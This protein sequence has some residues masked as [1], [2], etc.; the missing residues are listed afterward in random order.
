MP[1]AQEV[2]VSDKDEQASKATFPGVKYSYDYSEGCWQRCTEKRSNETGGAAK[3]PPVT[4]QANDKKRKE[5]KLLALVPGKVIEHDGYQ[6][7]PE[8]ILT[9]DR[10]LI[11]AT[12]S[13]VVVKDAEEA[14]FTLQQMFSAPAG[15]SRLRSNVYN[16]FALLP[17]NELQCAGA[18]LETVVAAA[19]EHWLLRIDHNSLE[20]VAY[21][22]VKRTLLA[23]GLVDDRGCG[24]WRWDPKKAATTLKREAACERRKER[25]PTMCLATMRH[26]VYLMGAMVLTH[27]QLRKLKWA[28][29][30]DLVSTGR[31]P[32]EIMDCTLRAI[33]VIRWLYPRHAYRRNK[34]FKEWVQRNFSALPDAWRK[35]G[36]YSSSLDA[37]Y[38]KRGRY[39]AMLVTEHKAMFPVE[40]KVRQLV[41]QKVKAMKARKEK[42]D[43]KRASGSR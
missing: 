43:G 10:D 34:N 32:T 27:R 18:T 41:L 28:R 17:D 14:Q 19:K 15:F 39:I 4:F 13:A 37:K 30:W 5:A 40:K 31:Y 24:P 12:E 7:P 23:A 22:Q 2:E 26:F 35:E 3:A 38:M 42:I 1:R 8:Y 25:H 29:T 11:L 6:S 36:R 33:S 9:D 21:S 16:G 20:G